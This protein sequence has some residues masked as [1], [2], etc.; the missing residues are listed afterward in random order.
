MSRIL[1]A[2]MALFVG[3]VLIFLQG[4]ILHSLLPAAAAPNLLLALVVFLAF[5]EP[6]VLG[7]V[8]VFILGVLLDMYSS[9]LLVGPWAAAYVTV[10]A[11][12]ALLSQRLFVESPWAAAISVLVASVASDLIY[13]LL[14]MEFQQTGS[15]FIS[16]AFVG[17]IVTAILSPA[18]FALYRWWLFRKW[19]A[20]SGALKAG[21]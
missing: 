15:H 4:T 9:P 16:V 12:V 17:A 18:L 21:D 11:A 14:V 2:G 3:L 13:L 5:Y 1:R 20:L 7:A 10:F 8:V 6:T 19:W